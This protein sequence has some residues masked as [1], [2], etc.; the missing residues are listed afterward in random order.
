MFGLV[1]EGVNDE[2]VVSSP[3]AL[4]EGPLEW[5]GDIGVSHK[6]H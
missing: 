2:D 6:L 4:G 1:D 3:V 5:V